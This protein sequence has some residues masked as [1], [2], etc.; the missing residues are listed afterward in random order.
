MPH[1]PTPARDAVMRLV[2]ERIADG[3]LKP[4]MRAPSG[5]ALA[6]ETGH[7]LET[8]RAA[9]RALVAEGTL[10]APASPNGRP[11]VP[12]AAGA[13]RDL[14]PL[15]LALSAVLA[16]RRHVAGMTQQ[17]LAEKLGVT[18]TSVTHAETGRTWQGRGFWRNADALLGGGL[19]GLYDRYKAREVMPEPVLTVEVPAGVSAV[20]VRWPDGTEETVRPRADDAVP[21]TGQEDTG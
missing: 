21:V 11:R 20:T 7:A 10:T 14:E 1:G 13:A 18:T 8:V 19:L 6:R 5:V 17:E 12:L 3:T 2:R 16:A 15:R 9:L 4:G